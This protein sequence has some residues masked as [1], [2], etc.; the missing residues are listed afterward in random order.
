MI[1][2]VRNRCRTRWLLCAVLSA[3]SCSGAPSAPTEDSLRVLSA[4]PPAGT[5]LTVGSQVTLTYRVTFTLTSNSALVGMILIPTVDGAIM[6]LDTSALRTI[7]KGTTTVT[8]SDTMT[9]PARCTRL[10]AFIAMENQDRIGQTSTTISYPV[11]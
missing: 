2:D 4:V 8:L 6:P 3:A 9:I 11:Q 1:G 7:N 5:V 10:E